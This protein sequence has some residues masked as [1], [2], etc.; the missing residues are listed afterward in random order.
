M[1]WTRPHPHLGSLPC[2]VDAPIWLLGWSLPH[3][4]PALVVL[5]MPGFLFTKPK[6]EL[7]RH[8]RPPMERIPRHKTF[9]FYF[10]NLPKTN[11]RNC[12]YL[13]FEVRGKGRPSDAYVHRGVFQNQVYPHAP[14]HAELCFLSWFQDEMLS[15]HEQQ[16]VTW[17]VS[18]SP[19]S[20]CAKRVAQFLQQH[21]NVTL[22]IFAARL[23]YFWDPATR[24]GLR[25]LCGEGARV[26][27]MSLQDFEYCWDHFVNKKNKSFKPW[28]NLDRNYNFLVTELEEIR[29]SL[30]E[31][32]FLEN[33]NNDLWPGKTCLCYEVTAPVSD[34]RVPLGQERGFLHSKHGTPEPCCH[35]EFLLLERILSWKLNPKLRYMVNCFISWSPCA[36]C[37]QYIA[38]FL[39]E[40][41]HVHLYIFASRI[42]RRN[43][44]KEGLRTVWEAGAQMAIMNYK[45]FQYCWQTFV[46]HQGRPFPAWQGLTRRSSRQ[47]VE[48]WEILQNQEN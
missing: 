32:T 27:I 7:H 3:L 2:S 38:N 26:D 16:R 15:P 45:D 46:D 33:F 22:S 21:R 30:D 17:F 36:A 8:S 40:N 13:C 18:W 23:S 9:S 29:H 47:S 24:Q 11:I 5:V 31:D 35:A 43:D 42:Y 10:R 28:W 1:P 6:N 37:A 34:T 19:C 12:N 14:R 4:P 39:R 41:L 44:Y 48:L 25:R 20:S